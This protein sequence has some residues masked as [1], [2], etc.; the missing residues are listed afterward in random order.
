[1]RNQRA[2]WIRRPEA[3]HMVT[4]LRSKTSPHA[5]EETPGSAIASRLLIRLKRPAGMFL[6]DP[7]LL[8]DSKRGLSLQITAAALIIVDYVRLVK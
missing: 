3:T 5:L 2:Y 8:T 7:N 6:H 4:T 1:M